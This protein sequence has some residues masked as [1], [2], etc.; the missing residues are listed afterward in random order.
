MTSVGDAREGGALVG[1]ASD[2]EVFSVNRAGGLGHF[3]PRRESAISR[4]AHIDS[5]RAFVVR[6]RSSFQRLLFALR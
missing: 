5:A 2:V 1:V 4:G 3:V 6:L